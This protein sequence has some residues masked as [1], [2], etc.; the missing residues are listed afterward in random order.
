[1]HE[2]QRCAIAVA[3][4]KVKA[5]DQQV[6]SSLRLTL[7]PFIVGGPRKLICLSGPCIVQGHR[8]IEKSTTCS[9]FSCILSRLATPKAAMKKYN[10]SRSIKPVSGPESIKRKIYTASMHQ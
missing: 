9:C 2:G 10:I 4:F 8:Q 3:E 5:E 1:M 6:S 7:I